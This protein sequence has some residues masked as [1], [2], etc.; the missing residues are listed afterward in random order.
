VVAFIR[1]LIYSGGGGGMVLVKRDG[2]VLCGS[3]L[4]YFL[5]WGFRPDTWFFFN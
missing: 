2:F 1:D 3:W 4:L 5:N